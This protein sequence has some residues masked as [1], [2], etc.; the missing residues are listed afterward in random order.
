MHR[1]KHA[2]FLGSICCLLLLIL[3]SVLL[4]ACGSHQSSNPELT[5]DISEE[6]ISCYELETGFGDDEIP[7]NRLVY[8][9][10][11]NSIYGKILWNNLRTS[12]ARINLAREGKVTIQ[13]NPGQGPDA[14]VTNI[15]SID[16]D[17]GVVF[18]LDITSNLK[19][20]DSDGDFVAI[21]GKLKGYQRNFH[22]DGNRVFAVGLDLDGQIVVSSYEL[23]D[24]STL[25]LTKDIAV[26]P[27]WKEVLATPEVPPDEI[28]PPETFEWIGDDALLVASP[29]WDQYIWVNLEEGKWDL[30]PVMLSHSTAKM[31]PNNSAPNYVCVFEWGDNIAFVEVVSDPTVLEKHGVER[32]YVIN[33]GNQEQGIR[34]VFD[35]IVTECRKDISSTT[36]LDAVYLGSGKIL[37]LEFVA[38]TGENSSIVPRY[39][40]YDTGLKDNLI[41]NEDTGP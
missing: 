14:I 24:H 8:D 27:D 12:Y 39:I 17:D 22:V 26:I 2:T 23:G 1:S 28:V 25:S 19:L 30:N 11:S 34:F 4:V 9:E 21:F 16:C 13:G 7:V 41:N 33:V 10:A 15:N 36:A 31:K 6:H 5:Q 18:L 29:L 38:K 37:A 20:Y 35:P 40:V 32:H 3:S